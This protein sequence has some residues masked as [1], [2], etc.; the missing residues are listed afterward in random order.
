MSAD[1]RGSAGAHFDGYAEDYDGALNQGL[2]ATGESKDFFAR[3]RVLWVSRCLR[4]LSFRPARIMDYGCGTGSATPLLSELLRAESIIGVDTSE[5]SLEV[6]RRIHSSSSHRFF[7]NHQY[8]P[9]ASLDLIYCNGVFH[10][11]PPA[12]RLAELGYIWNCLRPGGIFAFWENNPWNPGTR[13]VMSRIP[14]DRDA[15][16]LTPAEARGLLCRAGFKII[17]IDFLF[18]FPSWLKPLRRIEPLLSRLPVG[19]QF[20]VLCQRLATDELSS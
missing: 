8:K 6:A 18:I 13:Y 1:N 10:H 3:E 12:E 14:F 16:T 5:K 9:E 19:G 2:S 20:Q 4:K 7:P 17:G 11:I 15:V